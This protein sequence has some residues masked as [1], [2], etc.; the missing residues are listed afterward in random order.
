MSCESYKVGRLTSLHSHLEGRRNIVQDNKK[1]LRFDGS[2]LSE[3]GN[4]TSCAVL[5]I[6][7]VPF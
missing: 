6:A 1:Q 5:V 2:K 4:I 7:A 3:V